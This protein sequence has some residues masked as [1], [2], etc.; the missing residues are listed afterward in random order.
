MKVY[1]TDPITEVFKQATTALILG[2]GPF[3]GQQ[4]PT[5]QISVL[6]FNISKKKSHKNADP[7]QR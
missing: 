7:K 1:T 3:R 5:P 6:E 2:R 4:T